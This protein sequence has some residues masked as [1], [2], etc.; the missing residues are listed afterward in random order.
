MAWVLFVGASFSAAVIAIGVAASS[1]G[2][3]GLSG[4]ERTSVLVWGGLL[5]AVM[6]PVAVVA[7]RRAVEPSLPKNV[8]TATVVLFSV[9]VLMSAVVLSSSLLLFL[10]ATEFL[11]LAGLVLVG[12]PVMFLQ[13][14]AVGGK[15]TG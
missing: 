14:Q 5:L 7:H 11:F 8:M 12:I 15:A 4:E 6:I 1:F 3:S 10:S 13:G 2:S 9:L